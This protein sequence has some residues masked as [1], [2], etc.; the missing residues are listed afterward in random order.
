MRAHEQWRKGSASSPKKYFY[1][2]FKPIGKY[3][4][5]NKGPRIKPCKCENVKEIEDQLNL[6]FTRIELEFDWFIDYKLS[7]NLG[8][9][10][11]KSILFGTKFSIK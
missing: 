11:T 2:E 5:K 6:N 10:S 7:I 3:T 9:D 1:F 8:E 4:K